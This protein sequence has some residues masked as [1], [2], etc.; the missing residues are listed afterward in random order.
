[1]G[2]TASKIPEVPFRSSPILLPVGTGLPSNCT[3]GKW[4]LYHILLSQMWH[5]FS[6]FLLRPGC[7]ASETFHSA[8]FCSWVSLEN[9]LTAGNHP[10]LQPECSVA[11]TSSLLNRSVPGTWT[12]QNQVLR[13]QV[14][15]VNF[16]SEI[17]RE[18]SLPPK[19]TSARS[20]LATFLS[21]LP[22][23]QLSPKSSI[24]LCL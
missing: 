1:M 5:F 9:L 20:F 8:P 24:M 13:L 16:F 17:P 12:Q 4:F 11:L 14:S 21:A 22:L 15:R 6:S 18:S 2:G 10:G 7:K 19:T 23:S 3:F